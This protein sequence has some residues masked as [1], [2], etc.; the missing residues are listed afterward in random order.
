MLGNLHMGYEYI[1]DHVYMNIF[2]D[3]MEYVWILDEFQ[4]VDGC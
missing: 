1:Y 4:F 2:W 3:M